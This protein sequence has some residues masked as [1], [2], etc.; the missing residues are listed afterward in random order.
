MYLIPGGYYDSDKDGKIVC[1]CGKNNR[2]DFLRQFRASLSFSGKS[3]YRC[4]K[5]NKF[6][7]VYGKKKTVIHVNDIE[8]LI[9]FDY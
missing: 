1:G 2:D 6:I 7:A 4:K 5:C 3:I 8:D 9:Q